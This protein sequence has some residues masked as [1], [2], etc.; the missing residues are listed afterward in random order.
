MRGIEKI[1]LTACMMSCMLAA[2]GQE[3]PKREMRAA[4][5]STVWQLDWPAQTGTTKAVAD[6]QKKEL[7]NMLD[8]MQHAGLNAVCFQVRSMA[9]AMYASSYEPW[10][11]CLTGSRGKAPASD[12]DP[13][14]YCVDACHCRGMEC[15][16]W[17]NPF[18]FSTS[19]TLPSTGADLR[20]IKEGWIISYYNPK[21]KVKTSILDPGNP[22]A[23]KHIVN[24]CREIITSYDVDG[25]LFD[26]YFY[27]EGLP[28]GEGYDYDEWVKSKTEDQAAWRRDN[29]NKAVREV[30]EMII[31]TRDDVRFGISPAGVGGGD[32]RAVAA[33]GLPACYAGH[34]WMYDGIYC[35]PIAWL[36]E[37]TVD[38]VSPQIYW[39]ST[40]PT[41]PYEPI[42]RWWSEVAAHF[43]R[44]SFASHTV[45][46]LK[47]KVEEKKDVWPEK[48]RQ[49]QFNRQCADKDA[50][51]SIIYPASPLK[52]S[53]KFS[54]WIGGNHYKTPAIPPALSW[55]TASD[56]GAVTSLTLDKD[57]MLSWDSQNRMR[58]IVY[59][60]PLDADM[61]TAENSDGGFNAEYILGI[62]YRPS[63]QLDAKTVNENWI[64]VSPLDRYGNE[65]APMF[66][67]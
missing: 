47:G 58:Y 3:I 53:R 18:R 40:H 49:M 46:D 56:P 7:D 8:N 27:P 17:V 30:Y 44:H 57:Y 31:K 10:S 39:S 34:D 20:A 26:D 62:T 22:D 12:W 1:I 5:I 65:W 6:A 45:S 67:L 33:H 13:L 9:D 60:I 28:L 29:V 2:A 55:R 36:A 37:G 21:T 42:S 52:T 61:Q 25:L 23:R 4:W 59:A 35:D 41:N 15:H 19:S 54:E 11:S 16:A 43:N 32:G 38:Y 14:K 50:P 24:V 51:G 48:L 64:V 66:L 63:Y